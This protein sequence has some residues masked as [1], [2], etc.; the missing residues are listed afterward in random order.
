MIARPQPPLRVHGYMQH[1][2]D[3]RLGET[4]VVGNPGGYN[5]VDGHEFDPGFVVEI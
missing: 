5:R 4:R 1:R 3:E 2:V